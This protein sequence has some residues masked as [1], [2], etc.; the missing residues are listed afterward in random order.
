LIATAAHLS[1]AL[2]RLRKRQMNLS[3][4]SILIIGCVFLLFNDVNA[5]CVLNNNRKSVKIPV[6]SG[7]GFSG[8]CQSGNMTLTMLQTIATDNSSYIVYTADTCGYTC[9]YQNDCSDGE[10]QCFDGSY[11]LYGSSTMCITIYCS[12]GNADG[13]CDINTDIEGACN[14]LNDKQVNTIIWASQEIH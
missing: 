14:G 6:L 4:V 8:R 12:K 10:A 9:Q 11:P 3:C 1:I 13:A 7:V 2:F 5:D